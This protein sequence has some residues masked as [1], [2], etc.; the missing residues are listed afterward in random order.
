VQPVDR[1]VAAVG[2]LGGT[3]ARLGGLDAAID[4]GDGTLSPGSRRLIALARV[5]VSPAEIVVLDEATCHLDP[6]AEAW[7]EQAFAQRPGTLVVIA[8]QIS[9]ALRAEWILMMDAAAT[10]VGRH[11]ELLQRSALYAQLVGYWTDAPDRRVPTGRH[12][13]VDR[14]PAARA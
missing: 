6:V 13:L 11:E 4:P 1:S 12:R 10:V 3:V 9:S 8:H 7:A 5:Y 14:Q 2:H